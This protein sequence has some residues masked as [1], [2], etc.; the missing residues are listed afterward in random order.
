MAAEVPFFALLMQVNPITISTSVQIVNTSIEEASLYRAGCSVEL[1]KNP[2][3]VAIGLSI[4]KHR[5]RNPR[6]KTQLP[7]VF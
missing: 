7:A 1:K 4:G 5:G 3:L 6:A 2:G